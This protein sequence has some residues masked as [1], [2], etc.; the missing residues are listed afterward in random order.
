[1]KKLKDLCLG[2]LLKEGEEVFSLS[3]SEIGNIIDANIVDND[4]KIKF[5]TSYG[6]PMDLVVKMED[7]KTWSSQK[8][9]KDMLRQFIIDFISNS[10]EGGD[11]LNEIIDDDLNIIGDDDMPTNSTNSMVTSP[12]FDLEKIYK[13]FVPK[14]IKFY[15]GSMGGGM[16]AW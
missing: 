5:K 4:I 2:V 16:I 1:M 9:G 8:K 15:S 14:S 13:S 10:T 11:D 3:P 12:K 6:K 7:F